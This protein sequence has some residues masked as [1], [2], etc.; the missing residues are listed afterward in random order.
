MNSSFYTKGICGNGM[1]LQRNSVNCVYGI[2]PKSSI[3]EFSFRNLKWKTEA[4]ENG[5][6]KFEF[7]PGKEG[8]PDTLTLKCESKTITFTDV[9]T[10]EVW[11]NS[12]QSNAQLPMERM[13]YSY[14]EEFRLP[15]NP[16]IRMITIPITYAA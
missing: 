12:G 15:E 3:V 8:G 10:G 6:W 5:N 14:P 16:Y 2:A 4:D 11:V 13:K 9:F 7:N 1:V